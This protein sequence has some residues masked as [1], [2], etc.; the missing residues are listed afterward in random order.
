MLDIDICWTTWLPHRG[1]GVY[2]LEIKTYCIIVIEMPEGMTIQIIDTF[3]HKL[4]TWKDHIFTT[5]WVPWLFQVGSWPD[6]KHKLSKIKQLI[7]VKVLDLLSTQWFSTSIVDFGVLNM[8]ILIF[9][10]HHLDNTSISALTSLV[11]SH[12]SVAVLW[13]KQA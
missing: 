13:K 12:L 8:V 9:F 4:F 3:W 1:K 2:Q 5:T 6:L 7:W 10:Y 11:H